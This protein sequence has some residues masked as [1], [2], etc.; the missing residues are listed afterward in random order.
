MKISIS[1]AAVLALLA[2]CSVSPAQNSM[3][4]SESRE[5]QTALAETSNSPSEILR[6][7]E[8][9]LTKYPNSP[10]KDELERAILKS[11][12][13]SNDKQRILVYGE[14]SLAKNMDQP[15][16]LER[17]S[18]ALLETGSAESAKKA[19]TYSQK[20]EEILRT[21]EKEGPSSKRNRAQMLEELDR[22][23]G[24]ALMM[25]AKA[26]GILGKSEEAAS[27]AAKSWDQ[28]PSAA[29]AREA[30]H[31]LE[32][33][34]RN[35]DA[36]RRYAEAFTISD[37]KNTDEDRARDR[38]KM[39]ELYRKEKGTETGLGDLI[40][41]AYDQTA[42]LAS[43]LAVIQKERDPNADLE[44]PMQFT[45][46]AVEGAPLKMASLKGK[47]LV[48]DFWATW[49][50]PCRIQHPLYEKV[51]EK[52][53]D[54]DDV[55]FLAINTDEDPSVVKPF[56]E[57]QKWSKNVYFEDGLGGLLRV[58]SIPTTVIID[59]QGNMFSRMNGFVPEK[60]VDQL[61]ERIREALKQ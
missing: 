18:Q 19:L 34:G 31:W 36:I 53:K 16:V 39:A 25:Q 2:A 15:M 38:A 43:R 12:M 52:F 14:K 11:A 44:H 61:T 37:A 30:A 29:A 47:I 26:T 3:P 41:A 21:L 58:S 28:Y 33:A 23:L 50:G 8:K 35:A 55:V 45:L 46:S 6:T 4:D 57:E 60:F 24:R 7:L 40:L 10:Q 51:R 56:L 54:R 32:A 17:V 22:A 13:E 42:A 49:C 5:L 48:L 20:F 59:K 1:G 9:H 27:L